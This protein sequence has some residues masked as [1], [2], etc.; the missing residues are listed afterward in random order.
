MLMGMLM[1]SLRMASLA[2]AWRSAEGKMLS[3]PMGNMPMPGVTKV[4]VAP[5]VRK[6]VSPLPAPAPAPSF[7][8]KSCT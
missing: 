4:G 8:V 2:A 5:V 6:G 3:A 7:G 1:N